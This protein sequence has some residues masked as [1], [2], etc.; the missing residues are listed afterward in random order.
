MSMRK[1]TL[2]LILAALSACSS[3]EPKIA[4]LANNQPVQWDS[5]TGPSSLN[6][7]YQSNLIQQR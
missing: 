1:L 3:E 2:V 4:T 7:V 5:I 6:R